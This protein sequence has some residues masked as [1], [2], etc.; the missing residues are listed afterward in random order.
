MPQKVR[1]S[2]IVNVSADKVWNVLKNFGGV[3]KY[4]TGVETS[5]LLGEKEFGLGAKRQ[6]NFYDK[7]SVV[8]EVIEYEEGKRM[9]VELSEFSLPLK[10]AMA[11]LRVERTGESSCAVSASM[12]FVVKYGP[13]GWVMGY[14]MMRPMMKRI[15]KTLLTGMVYYTATGNIIGKSL[16]PEN[17]LNA[18]LYGKSS[19]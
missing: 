6:C 13:V 10:S 5:P 18:A 9:K 7:T 17:K 19:A 8:E 1:V 15:L 11:E 3:E 14:F 2:L 16:P 12:D 4:H